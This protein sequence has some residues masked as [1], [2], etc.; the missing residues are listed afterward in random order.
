[1]YHVLGRV[2]RSA[3]LAGSDVKCSAELNK[4]K[5]EKHQND[6]QYIYHTHYTVRTIYILCNNMTYI[7]HYSFSRASHNDKEKRW[8][9]STRIFS[10]VH[11]LSMFQASSSSQGCA[12]TAAAS[13][14]QTMP[15]LPKNPRSWLVLPIRGQ[16]TEFYVLNIMGKSSD[17][18]WKC[19]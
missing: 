6:S 3:R 1:M 14:L 5:L 7:F 10:H 9:L 11:L 13:W 19:H 4:N 18:H 15:Y 16:K 8:R 17:G 12:S 2:K